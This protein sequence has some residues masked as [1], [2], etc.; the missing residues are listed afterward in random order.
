MSFPVFI[1]KKFL[2]SKRKNKI[3]SVISNITILGIAIGVAVV[4][5]AVTILD[6]FDSA[7]REKIVNLNSHIIISGFSSRNLP[8]NATVLKTI[9]QITGKDFESIS[10]FISKNVIV[11]YK[12][13]SDGINLVGVDFNSESNEISQYI[14]EGSPVSSKSGDS[15]IIVGRELAEKLNLSIGNHLT[16]IALK[17]DRKPS[18]TNPP[19]FRQF[20][21]T[22]LYE[23]GMAEYD[24]LNAY[25]DI[26]S[27]RSMFQL[28]GEVS[29]YNLKLNSLAHIDSIAS[30]L[31]D[32][33]GY[34]FYVRTI[35]KQHQNIFTWLELQK[36]PIPIILGMII[37][38]AL[39][40]IIG[41]VLIIVLE[42]TSAIGV[43]KS[44]GSS[45]KQIVR[46]FLVTGLS[47]SVTG[48]IAGNVLALLLSIIQLK[49]N[50]I[51]IPGSIYFLSKVPILI[52]PVNYLVIS[53]IAF[54]VSLITAVIPS[55]IASRLSP[56][57]SIR[58]K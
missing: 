22:G 10:P 52:D 58:F 53:G 20:E 56:V 30:S 3:T 5:I 18:F 41:T 35:F 38:V 28:D 37:L 45:R 33:L 42:K 57:Q 13:I 40:N 14:Y 7:V 19:I 15:G 11:K 54:G 6:G 16:I 24:D 43:L 51:S 32:N 1:A 34:P 27:A 39:F 31:Q 17:N 23:S 44:L 25:I 47:L 8:D 2:G 36:K 21:L 50:V 48:I 4:I 26:K 29:G 46:I 12:T 9:S 49:L 55:I